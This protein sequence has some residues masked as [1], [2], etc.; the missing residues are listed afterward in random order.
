MLEFIV[1]GQI[2]GTETY[3]SFTDITIGLLG[4]I[5]TSIIG[6]S[7]LIQIKQYKSSKQPNPQTITDLTI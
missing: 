5:I 1:L 2:P 7:F 3:I 6:H 4:I